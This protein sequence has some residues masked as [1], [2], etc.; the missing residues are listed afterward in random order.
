MIMI[1][2]SN[3]VDVIVVGGNM[4]IKM[5]VYCIYNFQGLCYDFWVDVVV[6]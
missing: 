2:D 4:Y 3:I 1:V 5:V 6:W